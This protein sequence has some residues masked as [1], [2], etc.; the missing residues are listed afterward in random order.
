MTLKKF[1]RCKLAE[2]KGF[3][4]LVPCGTTVFKTA[5]IDR[6][7]IPPRLPDYRTIPTRQGKGPRPVVPVGASAGA[8]PHALTGTAATRHGQHHRR[9]PPGGAHGHRARR[10]T[11]PQPDT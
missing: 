6:S 10:G 9:T 4:P 7:A 11:A 5:A 1:K 8:H 2:S 3:E